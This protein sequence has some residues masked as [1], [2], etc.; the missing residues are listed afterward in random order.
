MASNLANHICSQHQNVSAFMKALRCSQV[1]DSLHKHTNLS[2]A[3]RHQTK[4]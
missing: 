4:P 3:T 1:A 2:S